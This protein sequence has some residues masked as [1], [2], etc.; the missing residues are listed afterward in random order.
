MELNSLTIMKKLFIIA[1]AVVVTASCSPD[2]ITNDDGIN[3]SVRI[4]P[5]EWIQGTWGYEDRNTDEFRFTS[6]DFCILA[7]GP[8]TCWKRAIENANSLPN[9]P[10][11]FKLSVSQ[12][13]SDTEYTISM[14]G[15]VQT[16][17][18]RFRKK[19]DT[20]I[21]RLPS[22]TPLVKR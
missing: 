9:T 16:A 3:S 6:N 13:I 17:T 22:N 18:F 2:Y 7:A 12:E 20:E 11:E 1:S 5:P 21:Y 4:T 10:E 8:E 19:S 15:P 14:V